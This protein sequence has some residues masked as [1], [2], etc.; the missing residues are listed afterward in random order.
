M[1]DPRS[2]KAYKL[3]KENKE[4]REETERLNNIINRTTKYVQSLNSKGRGCDI[5][6]DIKQDILKELKGSDK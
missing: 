1:I 5:Y 2:T 4:L 6:E 3:E